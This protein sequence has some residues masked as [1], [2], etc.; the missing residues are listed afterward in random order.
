MRRMLGV[1]VAL[2]IALGPRGAMVQEL[3]HVF[4]EVLD[5]LGRPV[6]DLTADDFRKHGVDLEVVSVRRGTSRPM[7]IALLVDNGGRPA[8]VRP[9]P[10]PTEIVRAAAAAQPGRRLPGF[11]VSPGGNGRASVTPLFTSSET[12]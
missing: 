7:R 2:G 3:D 12:A 1:A 11:S 10:V 9:A 4:V 5:Q 8:P 6:S